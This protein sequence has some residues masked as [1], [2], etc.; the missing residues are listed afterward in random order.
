MED[1]I[2]N[3]PQTTNFTNLL[4]EFF[5]S[6]FIINK[7]LCGFSLLSEKWFQGL[8]DVCIISKGGALTIVK[9]IVSAK[10]LWK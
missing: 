4:L 1:K 2:H 9:K 10:W 3:Y 6:L 8:K 5:N 7:I